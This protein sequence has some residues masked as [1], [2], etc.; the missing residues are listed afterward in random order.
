[1]KFQD[2]HLEDFTG[3]L[4]VDSASNIILNLTLYNGKGSL[5]GEVSGFN[6]SQAIQILLPGDTAEKVNKKVRLGEAVTCIPPKNQGMTR[7]T[8]FAPL[9]V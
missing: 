3:L 7:T 6:A 4:L 5:H 8:Q 1:M 2:S 9:K